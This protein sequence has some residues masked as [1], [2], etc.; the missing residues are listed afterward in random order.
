[1]LRSLTVLRNISK[2]YL[3][4][5]DR[6]IKDLPDR[7]ISDSCNNLIRSD[8]ENAKKIIS[9]TCIL[10]LLISCTVLS[11]AQDSKTINSKTKSVQTT[12]KTV[13]AK[14]KTTTTSSKSAQTKP[15]SKT[16]AKST[17]T[18]TKTP[19]N[20]PKKEPASDPES[21]SIGANRWELANLN[22]ST[23]RNGDSIPHAKSN[24]DWVAA[25]DAGKPAWCY[26][27]NNPAN[28]AKYGKLYN[29]YAVN[30]PRGLAPEGWMLTTDSDWS[31]LAASAGAQ[32]VAYY[33]K[34][35]NGWADGYNGT[36]KSG[37]NGLPGGYRVENGSF[38]NLGS[39]GIWWSTTES[40]PQDAVDH[41]L[42][43]AGNLGR[44]SSP[45]Q[46]GESVRCI[47]PAR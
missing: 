12:S 31:R 34:S 46:R 38:L 8:M 1:M 10:I 5:S 29:W 13:Q 47:R 22:V 44:S 39:V 33:L 4:T 40:R 19:V 37:F 2:Q 42:S 23:F 36:N 41:Y 27:N 21:V 3:K 32:N 9:A 17:G 7:F 6:I 14:K 11:D 16:G 35:G 45:K 18:K 30:D 20:V 24:K 15:K 43:D 25:G 26:Y 28:G